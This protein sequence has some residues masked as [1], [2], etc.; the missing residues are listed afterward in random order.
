MITNAAVLAQVE[1][2]VALVQANYDAQYGD[3]S[4]R[5]VFSFENKGQKYSRIVSGGSVHAFVDND[6]LLYKSQGWKAPAKDA[7]FDLM[8]PE[9]FANMAKVVRWSG[10]HLYVG[11]E[12]QLPKGY[13]IADRPLV[14]E[15]IYY[16][17]PV[18]APQIRF[19]AALGRPTYAPAAAVRAANRPARKSRKA[20]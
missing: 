12:G 8:D 17:A 11:V 4:F 13:T 6:G 15:R 3:R 16:N 9:S 18:E 14:T 19:D 10:G 7:R 2:Y 1:A 5:S 20:K